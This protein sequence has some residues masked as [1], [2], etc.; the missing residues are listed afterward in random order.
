MIR[1]AT[2]RIHGGD[3]DCSSAVYEVYRAA[4]VLPPGEWMWTGNETALLTSNGFEIVPVESAEGMRRGDVLLRVYANGD[5]HTELYLGDG[6]Q[7]G[8]RIDEDGTIYGRRKGDQTGGEIAASAY[9]P[10][11]WMRALRYMGGATVHGIPAAEAAAQLMEHLVG[12]DA[13]HGYSQT[14]R[15]GDGT[16]EAVALKWDDGRRTHMECIIGIKNRNTLVWYDGTAVNDLTNT[17]DLAVVQK[18][19]RATRGEDLPRI[20][21]T[22]EEFARFCQALKGGYPKHLKA[23]VDKYPTRSPEA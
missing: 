23:I 18:V 14:N 11:R 21:L 13:G 6:I 22:E 4:G 5:G 20:D 12:H 8:A 15:S 10:D 3:Y 7:A 1:R 16:S 9:R 19:A 17:A 2:V